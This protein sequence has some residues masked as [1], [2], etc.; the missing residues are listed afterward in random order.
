M[1]SSEEEAPLPVLWGLSSALQDPKCSLS[2]REENVRL[3]APEA[4][5]GVGWQNR[6]PSLPPLLIDMPPGSLSARLGIEL[7][8]LTPSLLRN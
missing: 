1:Q 7:I 5:A 8:N 3:A 2:R 4:E 6:R